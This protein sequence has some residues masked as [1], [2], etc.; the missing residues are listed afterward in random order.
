[1][2]ALRLF[3]TPTSALGPKLGWVIYR[4]TY[5]DDAGWEWFK[6]YVK[7]HNQEMLSNPEESDAPPAVLNAMDWTFVSDPATLDGA[8]RQQLRHRFRDWRNAAV[9]AENPRRDPV[10]TRW[11]QRYLFFLR[12]DEDSLNSVLE[13]KGDW[14]D[15]DWVQL[16]RCDEELDFDWPLDY[17]DEEL[18]WGSDPD[19]GREDDG[20]MMIQPDLINGEFYDCIGTAIEYWDA[21]YAPPPDVVM[22]LAELNTIEGR[23][24]DCYY[25]FEK[26]R[27][28][29]IGR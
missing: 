22:V 29:Y 19:P 11:T 20:W 1:M 17:K 28:K 6:S 25:H 8:S 27:S 24:K 16:I 4:T 13:G 23:I 12:V 14:L 9:H 10:E 26:P 21:Y 2:S 3:R 15:S 5:K 7:A 18:H